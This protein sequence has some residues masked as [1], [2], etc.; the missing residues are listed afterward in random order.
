MTF[1][2]GDSSCLLEISLSLLFQYT[3]FLGHCSFSVGGLFSFLSLFLFFLTTT[4]WEIALNFSSRIFSF[5]VFF[6]WLKP[7]D[8][9]HMLTSLVMLTNG[10]FRLNYTYRPK[11]QSWSPL[12][13]SLHGRWLDRSCSTPTTQHQTFQAGVVLAAV[14]KTVHRTT[15]KI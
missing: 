6:T 2:L 13:M 5:S 15:Q 1:D 11:T 8:I 14:H 10:L 9:F 4:F 3:T 12:D 7:M